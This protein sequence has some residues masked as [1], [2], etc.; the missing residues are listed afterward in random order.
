MAD[1]SRLKT[2]LAVYRR[3]SVTHA[4]EEVHLTQPA[5]TLQIRALE[6]ELGRPLFHRRPRG[7][8]PTP[9]GKELAASISEHVDAI[10]T[11]VARWSPSAT[12]RE[13]GDDVALSGGVVFAGGPS[14]FISS[15]LVE[16]L[17][18][19]VKENCRVHILTGTDDEMLKAFQRRELDIAILTN[20]TEMRMLACEPLATEAHVLVGAPE[21]ADRY[22]APVKS[23]RAGARALT[24]APIIAYAESLPL[25]A[26]YWQEVFDS[27]PH[28]SSTVSANNLA[29]ILALAISGAGITVLPHHVCADAISEGSL[30]QLCFP[31]KPPK[32]VLYLARKA[33]P[34]PSPAVDRALKYLREPCGPLQ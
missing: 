30:V 2:F 14:E 13:G 31:R 9:A 11:A 4:A 22:N 28:D 27:R 26:P 10:E 8:E 7:V 1:L 23:G 34:S 18:K 20:P 3:G 16:P 17:M 24:D 12:N 29:S 25:V 15:K 6:Q 5:V 32:T 33:G 21:F 19:L